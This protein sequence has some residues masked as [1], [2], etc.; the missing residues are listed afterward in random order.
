MSLQ[1][2]V[3]HTGQ[4]LDADPVAFSSVDALKHWISRASEIP[5]ESQILLTPGGKHVK[6]QALLTEVRSMFPSPTTWLIFL[7]CRRRSLY[8]AANSQTI[9][10]L[11]Y[12]PLHCPMPLRPMTLQ[13][14][15]PTTQTLEHGRP[16]S[17]PVA[18]G[19][20]ASSSNRTPCPASPPD[21][22]ASKS[23]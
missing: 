15:F 3:A 21:I 2:A 13:T 11:P 20:S 4:R 22:L 23:Q 16:S 1:I 19:P 8:T 7:C 14:P 18:T 5:P 12:R 10:R 6:L 9:H 17:K